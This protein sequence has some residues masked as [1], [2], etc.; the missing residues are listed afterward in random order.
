MLLVEGSKLNFTFLPKHG[1]KLSLDGL[2][3]AQ[4]GVKY[5]LKK[6][7]FFDPPIV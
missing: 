1:E 4:N 2:A 6:Y 7:T 5:I 3:R